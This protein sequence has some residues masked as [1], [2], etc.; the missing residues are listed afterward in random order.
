[1]G[2]SDIVSETNEL[3]KEEERKKRLSIA[4]ELLYNDYI[5][6]PELTAFTTLDQEDFVLSIE[7]K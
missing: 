3:Q 4:A 6:D 5:N 7:T 1:M 2:T